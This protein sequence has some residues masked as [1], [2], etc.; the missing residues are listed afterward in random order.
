MVSFSIVC[1]YYLF[2]MDFR[3]AE[4]PTRKKLPVCDIKPVRCEHQSVA[5]EVLFVESGRPVI[6]AK[7]AGDQGR[8]N[9]LVAGGPT[10]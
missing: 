1:V 5:H 10:R 9:D 8:D 7:S 6:A 2:C 3:M 4:R